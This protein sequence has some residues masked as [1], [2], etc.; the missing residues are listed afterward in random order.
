MVATRQKP[1]PE[2][3]RIEVFGQAARIYSTIG[4]SSSSVPAPPSIFAR[5]YRA[6]QMLAA[7]S[8]CS[9]ASCGKN[10]NVLA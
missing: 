7:L 9:F 3:I 6:Q 5:H 8:R 2:R 10:R 1:E 4:P